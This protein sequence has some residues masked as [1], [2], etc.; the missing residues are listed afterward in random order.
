MRIL[1]LASCVRSR[2]SKA[3]IITNPPLT[4]LQTK[5]L[6]GML[7][8]RLSVLMSVDVITDPVFDRTTSLAHVIHDQESEVEFS[9]SISAPSLLEGKHEDDKM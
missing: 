7:R 5:W 4:L 3:N 6:L 8:E 1:S 2:S 9:R